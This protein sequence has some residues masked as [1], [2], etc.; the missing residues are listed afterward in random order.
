MTTPARTCIQILLLLCLAH[1]TVDIIATTILP[2]LPSMEDQ[3]G[4]QREG[5]LYG[6]IIW[7]ITD[8]CGQMVFGF[9]GDRYRIRFII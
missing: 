5:F 8:T 4:L 2:L 9:L 3:M 6:Y 7:R 1:F